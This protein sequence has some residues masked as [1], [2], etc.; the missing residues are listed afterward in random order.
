MLLKIVFGGIVKVLTCFNNVIEHSFN[1]V[2]SILNPRRPAN[3]MRW[4]RRPAFPFTKQR[5]QLEFRS[6]Q[7]RRN[8]T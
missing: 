3:K 8:L 1:R 5:P 7:Q 6:H 2:I 4:S